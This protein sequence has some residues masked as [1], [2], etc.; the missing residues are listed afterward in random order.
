MHDYLLACIG[1][2][3]VIR[4]V[5][6]V[7]VHLIDITVLLDLFAVSSLLIVADGVEQVIFVVGVVFHLAQRILIEEMRHR[8]LIDSCVLVLHLSRV[9]VDYND[10]W[11]GTVRK[12][13]KC[14]LF[15]VLE[16]CSQLIDPF[17]RL[18]EPMRKGHQD[19]HYS[20]N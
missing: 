20:G 17:K 3:Q 2:V 5:P 19:D 13:M 4:V 6:G 15:V 12:Q 7:R 8:D 1:N 16:E 18:I 11:I 14:L 9:A 10:D